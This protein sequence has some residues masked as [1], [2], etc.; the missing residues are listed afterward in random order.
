MVAPEAVVQQAKED[1]LRE[2]AMHRPVDAVV[3]MLAWLRA[4]AGL[5]REAMLALCRQGYDSVYGGR[6]AV[7]RWIEGLQEPG[8]LI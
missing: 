6:G 8:L 2:L 1:A 3:T 4:H 7:R 5:E